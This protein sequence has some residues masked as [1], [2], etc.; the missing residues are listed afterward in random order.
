MNT[1]GRTYLLAVL[2]ISLG[3][4]AASCSLNAADISPMA[5]TLTPLSA[6]VK[7]T[8]TARAANSGSSND[9]NNA[10][11]TA[12][13]EANLLYSTQTAIAALNEPSR[14]ATATAIAP[15]VAELPLYGAD[16]SSGYVGWI[17]PP[18]TI[19]LQ[20]YHQTG[21]ANNFQNITAGDFVMAADITWHTIDSASGCGFMFRSNGDKNQPSQ[22]SVVITRV[23]S[24]QLA[25]LG[26]VAGKLANFHSFYPKSN[27][28][29]FSWFNDATNHLAVV[30]HGKLIDLYTNGVKIGEVDVTQP[31]SS[32]VSNPP[33]PELPAG[34]TAS[35]VQDYNNQ[36]S[37]IPTGMDQLNGE[38]SQAQQ[39][40][41]TSNAVLTDGFLGFI[42]LSES[43][44]TSCTFNNAWL[45]IQVK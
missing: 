28:K 1:R 7:G 6:S 11:A 35:Q 3:M 41:S 43:G 42:G 8:I 2:L 26:M 15:V 5:Q 23:A 20:G 17:H 40:F 33:S 21:Y 36:V 39:N 22:Y 30:A 32:P 18:V 31:P 38:L 29:S 37:Q 9:L 25:F 4:I 12:T 34:A 10:I 45:F 19:N 44:S 13:S 14:L 16:P 24:G 27:D